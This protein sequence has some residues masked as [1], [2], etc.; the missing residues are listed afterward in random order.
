MVK[1]EGGI[2]GGGVEGKFKIASSYPIDLPS[3]HSLV[4]KIK[5]NKKKIFV[6]VHTNNSGETSITEKKLGEEHAC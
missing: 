3:C 2:D 5:L 6:V 1:I 4:D